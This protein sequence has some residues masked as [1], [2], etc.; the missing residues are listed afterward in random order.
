VV[1]GRQL[2]Q[3][4]ARRHQMA[5]TA[6]V[7]FGRALLGT[8]L[9]SVFRKD[10]ESMQVTFK[11]EGPLGGIFVIGDSQGS[12]RGRVGNPECDLPL[13][14]QGNTDVRSAVG[15]GG[16]HVG[17]RGRRAARAVTGSL[18]CACAPARKSCRGPRRLPLLPILPG[19][20]AP[21][22]Q[23]CWRWSGRTRPTSSL[24]RAWCPSA[25]ARWRRT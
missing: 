9:L 17:P 2:V 24:T 7:A 11:S 6:A 3:E 15:T 25:A 22:A 12:V 18:L 20:A 16:P 8:L 10:Q 19:G 13:N 4:A 5:P 21:H 1:D 23:E 14:A